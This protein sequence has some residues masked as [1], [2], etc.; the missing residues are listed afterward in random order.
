MKH[1][2]NKYIRLNKAIR[3]NLIS[4]QDYKNLKINTEKQSTEKN[5]YKR[6]MLSYN[7]P[8]FTALLFL[9]SKTPEGRCYWQKI[10]QQI[11]NL[12]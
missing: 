10:N 4:I 1:L 2:I 11:L 9:W 8:D 3:L 6:I 7:K 12:K 5:K